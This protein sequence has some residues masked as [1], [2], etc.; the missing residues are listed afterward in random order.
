[1][2]TIFD[3]AAGNQDIDHLVVTGPLAK[4]GFNDGVCVLDSPDSLRSAE[5]PGLLIAAKVLLHIR[6]DSEISVADGQVH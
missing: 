5:G 1:M 6:H 4:D 3:L 2:R